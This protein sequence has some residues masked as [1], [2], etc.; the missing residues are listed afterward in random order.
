M[1]L[2]ASSVAAP[3]VSV[4]FRNLYYHFMIM[5]LKNSILTELSSFSQ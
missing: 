3:I 4:S 2:R 1:A 5:E